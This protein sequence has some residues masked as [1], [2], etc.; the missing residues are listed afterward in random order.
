V[1][2]DAYPGEI[3]MI[4]G[5]N[6]AGKS[7][8]F[9]VISGAMSPSKGRV[10]LNGNDLTFVD[11]GH[12]ARDVAI[13][14]QDPRV[15]TIENMTILEN[16]AFALR[17]G[18]RRGLRFFDTRDHRANIKEKLSLAGI[19]LEKRLYD[20]VS[21]LSGGQRQVLSL[22]MAL[23]CPSEILLLDEITA[24]LDPGMSQYMMDLLRRLLCPKS[25]FLMIT[26]DLSHAL[27]Y[28]DR[29]LVLREGQVAAH[30]NSYEKSQL[31]P[32]DLV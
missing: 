14:A 5:H 21:H 17:R 27:T 12:R 31:T 26:H 11:S 23:A 13:V 4:L 20:T 22:M 7:T 32:S 19:G 3:L 1:S 30:Y 8:L 10:I 18:Q 2:F 9:N 16:M 25:I 28:G 6:G 24:A 15:G 29:I